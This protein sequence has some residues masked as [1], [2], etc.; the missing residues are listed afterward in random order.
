MEPDIV[1]LIVIVAAAMAAAMWWRQQQLARQ[2]ELL[3][4]QQFVEDMEEDEDDEL[5]PF[6]HEPCLSCMVRLAAEQGRED[7]WATKPRSR[8]SRWTTKRDAGLWREM[9]SDWLRLT[10]EQR[11]AKY[12]EFFASAR[13]RSSTSSRWWGTSLRSKQ[14]K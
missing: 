3:V 13:P 4:L 11:D 2:E 5:L 8:R 1:V 7:I 9:N 12:K 14:Q 10:E 6:H